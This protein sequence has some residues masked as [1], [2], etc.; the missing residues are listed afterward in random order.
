MQDISAKK[1]IHLHSEI[2]RQNILIWN[3]KGLK[4]LPD[5]LIQEAPHIQQIY[6]KHN[7]LIKLPDNLGHFKSLTVLYLYGNNLEELPDSI[8]E[9]K[10]LNIL[11]LSNN[12]LKHLTPSVSKLVNLKSLDVANNELTF[13][14]TEISDLKALSLLILTGNNLCYLPES[15]GKL[16]GLQG[17]YVDNNAMHT[18]PHS[19][20]SLPLLAHLSCCHNYLVNLPSKPFVRQLLLFFDNNPELN[21][22]PFCLLKNLKKDDYY[23]PFVVPSYGCFA[24]NCIENNTVNVCF[25]DHIADGIILNLPLQLRHVTSYKGFDRLSL[26]PLLELCLRFLWQQRD[27]QTFSSVLMPGILPWPLAN[28][29]QIGPA[30]FCEFCQTVSIFIHSSIIVISVKLTSQLGSETKDVPAILYFC[31]DFCAYKFVEKVKTYSDNYGSWL[32]EALLF[33]LNIHNISST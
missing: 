29:L 32:K 31:S 7:L 28:Y 25:K 6:L 17:L 8:G 26:P 2:Q 22:L 5:T 4:T 30:V 9:I 19:L 24:K 10:T 33:R 12:K 11:N 23:N 16:Q 18:L 13:L 1:Y 27:N 3:Y 20:T 21:F 14:P 15:L